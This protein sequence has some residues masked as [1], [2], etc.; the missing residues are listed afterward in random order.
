MNTSS[1]NRHPALTLFQ[2]RGELMNTVAYTAIDAMMKDPKPWN[3]VV[4]AHT[5][6]C[7]VHIMYEVV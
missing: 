2:S 4:Q 6:V 3:A 1:T 5:R 7:R